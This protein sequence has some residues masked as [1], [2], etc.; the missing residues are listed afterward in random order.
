MNKKWAVIAC[1]NDSCQKHFA[2]P[3]EPA[4]HICPYCG[5]EDTM[6]TA[7]YLSPQL[8]TENGTKI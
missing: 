3:D 7:E 2:I 8:Y 4:F 6:G 1:E 5:S